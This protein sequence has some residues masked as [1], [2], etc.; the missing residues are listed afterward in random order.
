MW[1]NHNISGPGRSPAGQHGRYYSLAGEAEL[2]AVLRSDATLQEKS[3]ACRQLAGVATKEAV[4]TLAALLGDEKLSHMARY[5]LETIRDPS[6][7]DA[8]RDALGK[9]Q[10]SARLGVIGSLGVPVAMPRP[11]TP[12]AALAQGI[13]HR[14][15]PRPVPSAISAHRP[16][17][18]R[19]WKNALPGCLGQPRSSGHLRR[20]APL[21]RSVGGRWPGVLASQSHLRST[22]AA[23]PT[24]RRRFSAAALRG[25]IL[26]LEARTACPLMVETINGPDYAL[27]A[28]AARAAMES[29]APE[30]SEALSEAELPKVPADRKGLLML[31]LADRGESRIL[32]AVL[33]ILPKSS[34][35]STCGCLPSVP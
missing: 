8:L 34:D 19:P 22:C 10:G 20:P 23:W 32:P 21:C 30:V 29:P 2:L 14:P 15:R 17:P 31:A 12:L 5:A 33:Q 4:P 26:S 9:V 16:K 3:A 35:T 7:D 18:R 27:A 1:K 6:V 24:H 25:A 13:R 28:M 11:W